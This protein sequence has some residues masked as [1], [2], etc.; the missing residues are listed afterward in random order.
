PEVFWQLVEEHRAGL[1][2]F[3]LGLTRSREEARDLVS[4]TVLA[5]HRSFPKLR[6]REAFRKSLMTIA[7]R[8]YRRQRWRRRIFSDADAA[9]EMAVEFTRESSY[10]LDLLMQTLDKLPE[11]QREA[12]LLFEISDFSIEEIRTVQGGTLSGVKARLKRGREALRAKLV[13][14]N[15]QPK[16]TTASERLIPSLF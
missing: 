15:Y 4:E 14:K 6:D 13:D 3:A 12:I 11:R 7:A 9:P 10:D 5:A 8:I 2:R 16:T 1:W